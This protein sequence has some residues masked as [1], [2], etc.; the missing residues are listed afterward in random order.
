MYILSQR[1]LSVV[2]AFAVGSLQTDSG[3]EAAKG[4]PPLQGAFLFGS[5]FLR[6]E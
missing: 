3:S 2:M 4:R 1:N 6:E 5:V